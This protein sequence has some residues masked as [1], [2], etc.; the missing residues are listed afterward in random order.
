MVLAA[1]S[2]CVASS[3]MGFDRLESVSTRTGDAASHGTTEHVRTDEGNASVSLED[4]TAAKV[5]ACVVY[6][7]MSIA[8]SLVNKVNCRP[9]CCPRHTV[10]PTV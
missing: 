10:S 1:V 3:A 4:S 8:V 7:V 5:F 6:T 9:L 2:V